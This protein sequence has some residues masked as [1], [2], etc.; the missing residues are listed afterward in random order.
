MKHEFII[1]FY[2]TAPKR[3]EASDCIF[4]ECYDCPL[5][6]CCRYSD[7]LIRGKTDGK[8]LRAL[9]ARRPKTIRVT[10]LKDITKGEVLINGYRQ[11]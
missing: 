9:K 1:H 5:T 11:F 8:G 2:D 3:F 7:G 4:A 10:Y 6:G